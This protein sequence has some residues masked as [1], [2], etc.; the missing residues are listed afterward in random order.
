MINIP[1][2]ALSANFTFH[3][4]PLIIFISAVAVISIINIVLTS[5]SFR[6]IKSAMAAGDN[7][8]VIFHGRMLHRKYSN[9]AKRKSASPS[10]RTLLEYLNITLAVAYYSEND[11]E[12][13]LS[14]INSLETFLN[15]KYFW[16]GIY[17]LN[18]NEFE[19]ADE[20][21][22]KIELGIETEK[23]RIF[24]DSLKLYRQNNKD[25]AKEKITPIYD[26]LKSPVLRKITD[27]I[28]K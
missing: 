15:L 1:S 8:K 4:E 22:K 21:C 6:I 2:I 11:M 13:F 17:H 14:H 7:K 23:E 18:K 19:E 24:L 28:M 27:E 5:T 9:Y 3:P 26:E 20:I 10:T 16:L 12:N 25:A